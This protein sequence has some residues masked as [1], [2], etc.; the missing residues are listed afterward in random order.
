M[1]PPRQNGCYLQIINLYQFTANDG[2]QQDVVRKRIHAW[3]SRHPGEQ[4]IL[5]GDMNCSIQGGRHNYTHPMEKSLVETDDRLAKFCDNSK[6]TILSPAEFTWKRG[7]KRAKLD[8]G[9]S[10]NFPLAKPRSMTQRTKGSTKVRSRY[11]QLWSARG[12]ICQ[13]AVASHKTACSD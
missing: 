2:G 5:I 8:H 3:I 4:V 1:S 7:E 11:P 13:K 9:I 6:G 12:R 10:W